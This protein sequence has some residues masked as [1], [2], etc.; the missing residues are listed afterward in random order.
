MPPPPAPGKRRS[1]A[2]PAGPAP[3]IRRL[4]RRTSP[5]QRRSEPPGGVFLVPDAA[6]SEPLKYKTWAVRPKVLAS[7]HSNPA[8]RTKTP[9]HATNR[10]RALWKTIHQHLHQHQNHPKTPKN[11]QK[12]PPARQSVCPS[13]HFPQF[14]HQNR[15]FRAQVANYASLDTKTAIFV[16]KLPFSPVWTPEPPFP[17]SS[18]WREGGA[19]R[20]AGRLLAGDFVLVQAYS[21]EVCDEF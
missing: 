9:P 14:G 7:A 18:G 13:D 12:R 19:F 4:D 3:V 1:S 2:L 20:A 21:V 16:L 5:K 8:S 11:A 17:C 6:H 10:S 15:H